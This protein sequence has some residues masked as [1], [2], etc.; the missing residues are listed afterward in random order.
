MPDKEQKYRKDNQEDK[1]IGKTNIPD[2]GVPA[3]VQLTENL[4]EEI[5]EAAEQKTPERPPEK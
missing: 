2:Y 5:A 4:N 3:G 1:Y